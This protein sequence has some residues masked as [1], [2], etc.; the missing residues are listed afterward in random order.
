MTYE[1]SVVEAGL[2]EE[3]RK[4]FE[5]F[6]RVCGDLTA[7]MDLPERLELGAYVAEGRRL[8]HGDVPPPA[9]PPGSNVRPI[10]KFI[11]PLIK[12]SIFDLGSNP[13]GEQA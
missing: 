1:T 12:R 2:R 4:K 8:L 5:E 10:R 6:V 11:G 13:T 7:G 3:A 9:P